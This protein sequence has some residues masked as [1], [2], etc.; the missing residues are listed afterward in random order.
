MEQQQ[1]QPSEIRTSPF[2]S[3]MQQFGSSIVLMT[4]PDD[5]L[6]K[7]EL[8]FRSMTIDKENNPKRIP[9]A[10]PLMNDYG[11]SNIIGTVR[12]IVNQNTV[13]GNLDKNEV[14]MLIDFLGDTIA[15]DLMVNSRAYGITNDSTRDKIFMVALTTSFITMKR[16]F[17]EGERA[18]WKG[19]VQ[20]IHQ[21]VD[22][23]QKKGGVL[24]LFNP[25]AK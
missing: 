22:G 16:S 4:N 11:V 1:S 3:P 9:G 5:E 17:D 7:M 2:M 10:E 21:K 6:Y 8:T 19:S 15:K 24:S 18:F 20:E 14:P 13:M 25:F 23:P 12:S